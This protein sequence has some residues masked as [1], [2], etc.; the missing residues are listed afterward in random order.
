MTSKLT[1]MFLIALLLVPWEHSTAADL[2]EE[3]DKLAPLVRARS[4][5]YMNGVSQVVFAE[6]S[7]PDTAWE[8]RLDCARRLGAILDC[9]SIPVLLK[10]D[11]LGPKGASEYGPD[12]QPG[13]AVLRHLG[14]ASVVGVSRYVLD[15]TMQWHEGDREGTPELHTILTNSI[16]LQD[17]ITHLEGL[18]LEVRDP[19]LR[20]IIR[21]KIDVSREYASRLRK[22]NEFVTDY[23]KPLAV[24]SDPNNSPM[25]KLEPD[26]AVLP[27][28][29]HR[30]GKELMSVLGD[31]Q[32]PVE[33]RIRAARLLG[34][35]KYVLAMP[36]LIDNLSLEDPT[37]NEVPMTGADEPRHPCATAL[38]EFRSCASI[39]LAQ[40]IAK[41]KSAEDV[42]QLKRGILDADAF[43]AVVTH[44]RGMAVEVQDEGRRAKLQD[45]IQ[46]LREAEEPTPVM[47]SKGS[48]LTPVAAFLAGLVAG[49]FLIRKKRQTLAA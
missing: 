35:M 18:L 48:W 49:R 45:A 42:R 10:Y 37:A 27:E 30:V 31:P 4:R 8:L 41:A 9:E 7:D 19:I 17:A 16:F 47:A 12:E 22:L 38:A 46:I 20:I 5:G 44:L 24:T 2:F 28:Q 25:L 33:D 40:R 26:D 29:L 21:Q 34:Q 39:L 14:S 23:P 36:L 15:R 11:S 1:M 32:Q 13:R 3:A 6:I 43:R